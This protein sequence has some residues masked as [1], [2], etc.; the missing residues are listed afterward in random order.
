MASAVAFAVGTYATSIDGVNG[1]PQR[2]QRNRR[3]P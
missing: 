3:K 2:D 1:V